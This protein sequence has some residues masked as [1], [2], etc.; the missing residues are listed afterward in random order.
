MK[1]TIYTIPLN[2]SFDTDCEC[3][4]CVLKDRLETESVEY[5]LG[6]AMMEPDFRIESNKKGAIP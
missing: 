6:A 4:L 5:A 3:P 2:E 1:E